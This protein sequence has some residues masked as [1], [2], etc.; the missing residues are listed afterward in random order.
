[1]LKKATIAIALLAI[2]AALLPCAFAQTIVTGEI[3]GTLLDQTGAVVPGGS[4]VLKALATGEA[5]TATTG[6][7]G[8]FHFSLLRP[9]TYSVTATAKGFAQSEKQV[10]VQLGQV[11]DLK[12]Q[13]GV[14]SQTQVVE[15]SEAVSLIQSENAN[16]ATTYSQVQLENLPAGGMDMTAYAQTA[17]GVT[18]STGGGYG[19][20]HRVRSSRRIE[21][22]HN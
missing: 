19:N 5:K 14:Q 13:L 12:I 17:P 8:D 2:L 1:M 6:K 18:L 7:S 20:F 9:G 3:S 4:V 16:L 22:I 10:A 15:V 21:P 11:M